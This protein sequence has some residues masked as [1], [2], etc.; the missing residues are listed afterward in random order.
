MELQGSQG[1][2][3]EL[4]SDKSQAEDNISFRLQWLGQFRLR[5]RDAS[6]YPELLEIG[7]AEEH[8][9]ECKW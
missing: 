5:L 8:K 2:V 7:S 9:L 3:G 1:G 4:M 6:K